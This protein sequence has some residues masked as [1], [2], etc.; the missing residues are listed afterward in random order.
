M[1]PDPSLEFGGI[2]KGLSRVRQTHWTRPWRRVYRICLGED[3][4]CGMGGVCWLGTCRTGPRRGLEVNYDT[5][6]G[7]Q[8][9]LGHWIWD[10]GQIGGWG[11]FGEWGGRQTHQ[12]RL[13]NRN[14]FIPNR[15]RLLVPI[16]VWE[17]GL[18]KC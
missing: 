2:S 16:W 8:T 11:T 1:F 7:G 10:L 12:A 9:R 13:W 3:V 4:R 6:R 14:N 15:I 5:E 18:R 17:D